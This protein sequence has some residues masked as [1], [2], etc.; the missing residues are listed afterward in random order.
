MSGRAERR[1]RGFV[2]WIMANPIALSAAGGGL[3]VAVL[4][5]INL[6]NAAVEAIDPAHF[7]GPEAPRL[8]SPVY[9]EAPRAELARHVPNYSEL[10]GWDEGAAART[11]DCGPDC[12]AGNYAADVPYFGSREELAAARHEA[13]EKI[14]SDYADEI[15]EAARRAVRLDKG[16]DVIEADNDVPLEAEPAE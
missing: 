8:R 10:Y 7:S 13:L 12:G 9:E 3:I 4:I 11:A 15:A 6:G 5:G 16:E 1:L 14:D 2:S